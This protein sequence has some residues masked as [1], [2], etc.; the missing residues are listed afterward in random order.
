MRGGEG[1]NQGSFVYFAKACGDVEGH[2]VLSDSWDK[3]RCA[4]R[5]D[6]FIVKKE[7][8][9]RCRDVIG[10]EVGVKCGCIQGCC[11]G[12]RPGVRSW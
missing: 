1:Y 7:M 9:M 10:Q 3:P 12:A 5:T 4:P 2:A 11:E 8:A 6:S